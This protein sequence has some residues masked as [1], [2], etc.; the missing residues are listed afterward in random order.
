MKMPAYA[1]IFIDDKKK[2]HIP[3]RDELS[4]FK[5]TKPMRA[6]L[7]NRLSRLRRLEC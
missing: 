4:M 6:A 2:G 3:E 7:R 5:N 1:G